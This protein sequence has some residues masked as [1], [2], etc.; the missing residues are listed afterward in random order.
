[1]AAT[2]AAT[3]LYTRGRRGFLLAVSIAAL[4]LPLAVSG[5]YLWYLFNVADGTIS[6]PVGLWLVVLSGGLAA[7]G[8]AEA[9]IWLAASIVARLSRP[10]T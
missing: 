3:Y 4:G 8:L 10:Q 1:M 6:G 2:G 9:V 5:S 7:L